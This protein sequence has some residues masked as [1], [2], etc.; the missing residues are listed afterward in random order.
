MGS[1]HPIKSSD[2]IDEIQCY[3]KI[4]PWPEAYHECISGYHYKMSYYEG[5]MERDSNNRFIC[6]ISKKVKKKSEKIYI[7]RS[8]KR[9]KSLI[10]RSNMKDDGINVHVCSQKKL[11]I[12]KIYRNN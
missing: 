6:T 1:L 3:V 10:N 2:L 5:I 11:N 8:K 9:F 7:N 4:R 12:G